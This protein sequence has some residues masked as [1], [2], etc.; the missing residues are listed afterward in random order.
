[1][2]NV[3]FVAL[4]LYFLPIPLFFAG[5]LSEHCLN[6]RHPPLLFS[7]LSSQSVL[8][9]L[10]CCSRSCSVLFSFLAVVFYSPLGIFV[11]LY[12][13]FPSTSE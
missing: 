4:S 6:V 13:V 8:Y 3:F 2:S 10:G 9:S 12:S 11:T 7:V 1:M 5:A